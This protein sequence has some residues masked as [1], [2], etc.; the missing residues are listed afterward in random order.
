[1]LPTS[2]FMAN[3]GV[4]DLEPRPRSQGSSRALPRPLPTLG[5]SAPC[6]VLGPLTQ[7]DPAEGGQC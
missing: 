5:T 3:L 1:M 6:C 4:C 7:R 2:L